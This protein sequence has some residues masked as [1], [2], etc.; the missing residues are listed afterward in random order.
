MTS[1]APDDRRP[2]AP[3]AVEIQGMSKRFGTLVA[4]DD[5]SLALAPSTIHAVLGEN[6]AG[7]STLVKCVVGYH[8]PDRGRL[9][10]RVVGE[11]EVI[12]R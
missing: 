6:G 7:K 10:P 9:E 1:A 5:V 4:L 2:D 12:V 11:P 3:P 8:R